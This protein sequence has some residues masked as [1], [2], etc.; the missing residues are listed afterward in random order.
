MSVMKNYRLWNEVKQKLTRIAYL[1]CVNHAFVKMK[2][3]VLK[4]IFLKSEFNQSTA[5][6]HN[7]LPVR[8]FAEPD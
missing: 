3:S 2:D 4:I 1:N 5:G 6:V 7:R 8:S